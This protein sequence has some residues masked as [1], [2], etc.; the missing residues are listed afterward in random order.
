MTE[1][2][3]EKTPKQIT[4][5]RSTFV[6]MICL[7]VVLAVGTIVGIVRAWQ[8]QKTYGEFN[9]LAALVE[10]NYYTDI[11]REAAMDGA[12]KGYVSGLN[13]PYS[14][15]M[16]EEEYN[17]F[18]AEG[19]GEMVGIGVTV[20]VNDEGYLEVVDVTKDSPAEKAKLQVE[21]VIL[22][23]NGKDVAEL[24]YDD[25][26]NEVRGKENTTVKLSIRR[27]KKIY[28][29]EILR[30]NIQVVSATG[31]MLEDHIGY[32]RINAFKENTAEQFQEVYDT[33]LAQGAQALVFDVRDN[34]GGLVSSLEQILDPLLPEGVIAVAT[35]RDGTELPLVRSDEEENDMPMAVL[36]NENSASAAELFTASLSDF[37]KAEVVGETTFGKGIMQDTRDLPFGGGLTLTVA[38][39]RTVKGECYHQVGITPD[40]VVE[41]GA[42]EPDYDNP[43][44]E[45]D[46]QLKAAVELLTNS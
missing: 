42:Y 8:N 17:S 41:I 25:A 14:R 26:V 15:Y 16:T 29:R 23:V 3:E 45:N 35:Y 39:Y 33:L 38:T 40:H 32:I 2:T 6:S 22:T 30:E 10:Q 34:G 28:L 12:L 21:D 19:S 11:D 37:D 24:G 46:P 31:R 20:T 7:G 36:V 43:D 1:H 27:G 18:L 44:A 5:Q 13:D 4:M 9:T